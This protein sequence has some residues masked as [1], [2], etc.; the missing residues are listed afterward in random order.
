MKSSVVLLKGAR[1]CSILY[2]GTLSL[3]LIY[4]SSSSI[5]N[6]NFNTKLG[7]NCNKR[8][9]FREQLKQHA[10]QLEKILEEDRKSLDLVSFG[11]VVEPADLA[12]HPFYTYDVKIYKMGWDSDFDEKE[13]VEGAKLAFRTIREL[14]VEDPSQ[15]EPMFTPESYEALRDWYKYVSEEKHCKIQ[16]SLDSISEAQILNI[17]IDAEGATIVNVRLK[18][19]ETL[20]LED[21]EG[22]VV[23]GKKSPLTKIGVISFFRPDK[24]TDWQVRAIVNPYILTSTAENDA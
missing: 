1:S 13:F 17:R 10:S 8:N 21:E 20:Y 2:R 11:T 7:I 19:K 15:L 3:N 12:K 14:L 16:G 6:R 24:E 9:D 22:N 18:F 5:C 23:S 4:S